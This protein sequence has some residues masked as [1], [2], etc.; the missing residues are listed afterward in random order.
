MRKQVGLSLVELMISITLGLILMTGVVQMFLSSK[1][2]FSTQ[3]GMSRIQETGRLGIEFM[4][5]D[6]R[7]AARY[8]CLRSDPVNNDVILQD[9]GLDLGGLHTDFAEGVRGYDS[10]EDLPNGAVEDLGLA[11][12]RVDEDENIIV[13]RSAADVGLPVTGTNNATQV[14]THTDATGVVDNCVAD[15]CKNKAVI[16]SDCYSSRVFQVTDLAVAAN[17]LTIT[18][19]AGWGGDPEKQ[20]EIFTGSLATHVKSSVI[21]STQFTSSAHLSSENLAT[22]LAGV[23]FK[24]KCNPFFPS[25]SGKVA[26]I[27]TDSPCRKADSAA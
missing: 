10:V 25:N 16:V 1:K 22:E 24:S 6:I 7:A 5:R 14:F 2:V 15:I 11:E 21:F 3:Q 27:I 17:T 26:C 18:H 20:L 12:D 4:S 13:L 19:A 8:G 23:L 9:G